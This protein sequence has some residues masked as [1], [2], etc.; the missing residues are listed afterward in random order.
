MKY[1]PSKEE[2]V[3]NFLMQTAKK[4]GLER[5]VF[6]YFIQELNAKAQLSEEELTKIADEALWEW[7]I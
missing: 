4:Y 6:L 3:V 2:K 1:I 5:E 7:D